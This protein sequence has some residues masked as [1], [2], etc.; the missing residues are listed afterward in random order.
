MLAVA[1]E[2]AAVAVEA[3]EAAGVLA[4]SGCGGGV[5]G[6]FGGGHQ[7]SEK[8]KISNDLVSMYNLVEW[9][10]TFKIL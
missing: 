10:A 6:E 7:A 4:A 3:A 2:V 5:R 1:V 9:Q 8:P